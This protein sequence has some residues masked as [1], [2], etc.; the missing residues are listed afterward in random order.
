MGDASRSN[1]RE[2]AALPVEPLRKGR[3]QLRVFRSRYSTAL[4]HDGHRRPGLV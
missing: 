3:T 2:H 1:Q 4:P